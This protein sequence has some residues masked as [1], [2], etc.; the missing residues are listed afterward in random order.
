MSNLVSIRIDD[1]TLQAVRGNAHK[2]H[3]TQTDYIRTAI[4]RMNLKLQTEERKRSLQQAS[5][6]VRAESMRINAEFD[7]IE[8][9]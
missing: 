1:A 3:L 5:F 6:A 8:N 7:K 9:D 4:E 2:L